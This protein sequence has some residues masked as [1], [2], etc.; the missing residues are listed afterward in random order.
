MRQ[1][2]DRFLPPAVMLRKFSTMGSALTFPVQSLVFVAIAIGCTLYDQGKKPTIANIK[3]LKGTVR[4][5]GD[6]I[7]VPSTALGLLGDTLHALGLKVNSDKTFG[8]GKFRESCGEDAYSGHSV[9]TINVN[10]FPRKS[11]P[12]AVMSSVD[13]H[14]NL[15]NRGLVNTAGY[16]RKTVERLGYIFPTVRPASGA[17]G[18]NDDTGPTTSG[19]KTRWNKSLHRREIR[20]HTAK[21][22]VDRISPG[23]YPGVLQYFTEAAVVVQAS[24]SS[25]GYSARRPKNKLVLRWAAQP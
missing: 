16:I 17:L 9:A 18:W 10:E 4:V 15:Y 12:G 6:D 1:S 11:A 22:V 19:L 8:A 5:F 24:V 14:N 3:R 20:I 25:L 23:G 13:V 2:L 21:A 7:I